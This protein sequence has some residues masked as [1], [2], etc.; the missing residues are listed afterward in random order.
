M[1]KIIKKMAKEEKKAGKLPN[2]LLHGP[3]PRLDGNICTKTM[4]HQDLCLVLPQRAYFGR[5]YI[6]PDIGLATVRVR[7]T[8][9]ARACPFSFPTCLRPS[10][11]GHGV[12]FCFSWELEN[13]FVW[14]QPVFNEWRA[15]IGQ[16]LGLS[17]QKII[18]AHAQRVPLLL[19]PHRP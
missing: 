16:S 9:I 8:G 13:P 15:K 14:L 12:L 1:I 3:L 2:N 6:L 7:S 11:L 5:V 19:P 17:R 4:K 10:S 18:P